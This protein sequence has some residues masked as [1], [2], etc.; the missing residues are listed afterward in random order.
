MST[1]VLSLELLEKLRLPMAATGAYI[2]LYYSWML[3]MLFVRKMWVDEEV[4]PP[5]P[6]L[7]LSFPSL[8]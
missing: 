4:H 1:A 6:C 3:G 7:P 5:I 2:T 8:E